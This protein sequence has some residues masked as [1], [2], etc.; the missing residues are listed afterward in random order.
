MLT[1]T[2]DPS[3]VSGKRKTFQSC[4]PRPSIFRT[5]TPPPTLR[6][7]EENLGLVE[8][9]LGDET[10]D[11]RGVAQVDGRRTRLRGL[12]PLGHLNEPGSRGRDSHARLHAGS[13]PIRRERRHGLRALFG[14][15]LVIATNRRTIV[16]K[17]WTK[18]LPP[19]HPTAS[20]GFWH[21]TRRHRQDLP[22]HGR[23]HFRAFEKTR[24]SA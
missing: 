17:R 3:C 24:S 5:P 20:L 8:Q 15:P 16:P 1:Q 22:G 19:I 21:W 18:T 4:L 14:E 11:A 10:R 12:K 2:A 9:A 7:R 6:R 13:R 23:G